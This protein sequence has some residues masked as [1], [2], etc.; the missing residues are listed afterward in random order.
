MGRRMQVEH[1]KITILE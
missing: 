1:E